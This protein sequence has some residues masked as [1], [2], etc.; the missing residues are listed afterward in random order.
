MIDLALLLHREIE[1]TSDIL[2]LIYYWEQGR[3]KQ[4]HI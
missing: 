2:D 4:K 1:H 3:A